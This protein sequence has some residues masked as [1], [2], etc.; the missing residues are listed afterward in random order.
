MEGSWRVLLLTV[1]EDAAVLLVF[2]LFGR[3]YEGV[4]FEIM[5]CLC[6]QMGR[7]YAE[8]GQS[9]HR[10]YIVPEVMPSRPGRSYQGETMFIKSQTSKISRRCFVFQVVWG[11]G[12]GGGEG[13]M[14]MNDPKSQGLEGQNSWQWAK[15]A[16]LCFNSFQG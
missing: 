4:N 13:G 14:K 2:G 10:E 9:V 1:K 5:I 8:A 15:L 11:G 6:W 3:G 16:K 12:G 7:G